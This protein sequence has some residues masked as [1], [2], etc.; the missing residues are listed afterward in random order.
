MTVGNVSDTERVHLLATASLKNRALIALVTIV[1]AVFGGLALTSL[2][3]ELIPSIE[4][5]QIVVVTQYQGASPEVVNETVSTPIEQAVRGVADVESTSSTSSTG[6]SVVNATFRYGVDL[7]ASENKIAAAVSRIR[8]ALPAD[9]DPQVLSGSISDLPIVQLAVSSSDQDAATLAARLDQVAVPALEDLDGVRGVSVA[10]APGSRV[11]ITPNTDEL[12]ARGISASAIRD[13]VSAS[14][15]LVPAGT[16]TEDGKT[17]SVQSGGRLTSVDELASL[18]IT[19]RTGI[20]KISDVATVALT[21]DPVTSLSRVNG[22]PALTLAITK[23]PAANTVEVSHAV[24]DAIPGIADQLDGATVTVVF[25][26]APYIEKSIEALTTEGLLGLIFA[27]LVILVFLLSV[28]ATLV[29][30]ISIPVSVLITFVGMQAADYTLNILTLGGL[31]IAIGRVVDDSIVV[32]E[33]IKRHLA[34]DQGPRVGI[35]G[36]AVREVAGAITASTITTVTV[37]LPIA[38]VGDT[39]GELFRPFALTVTI[40]LL[41]S[42]LVSL[43]IVPVLAY[44]L[45]RAPKPHRHAPSVDGGEVPSRLQKRYLP[46]LTG[47]LKH[48][49]LTLTA[50]FLVL[51]ISGA[52]VPFMKTNFLG[53]SGQNT[54]SV[55]QSFQPGTSLEVQ[56]TAAQQVESALEQVGGI[57]TV[58][59]SL[60]T[61]GSALRDAFLGG[62]GSA[63]A[64]YSITTDEGADQEKLQTDVRAKLDTITGEGTFQVAASG[65]FGGSSTIDVDISAPSAD[66]LNTATTSVLD[67]VTGL[68]AVAE[69]ASN[70]QA[71]QPYIQV[72]VNRDEAARAGYTEVALAG[73]VSNAMQASTIG[74]IT[75]DEQRLTIYIEPTSA[76]TTRDALA[77][78]EVPTATGQVRLDSLASVQDVEGPA[79]ITSANGVRTATVSIT[80]ASDDLTTA[81]AE[82]RKAVDGLSL[83]AGSTAELGGVTSQQSDAFGQLGLALL[84]AILIVYVVMVATF[85]SLLQPVLLLVSVPFAATGA[86]LLQVV[87]GI[88]LGVPSLIGVLMLIGIVVTNAIVLIDL[89]NQYRE[90]GLRVREALVEGASRRLRPILMTALATIFAL[91]PMASGLTGGG[92]FISQPLAL[93]VIGG[94]LSS[95]LLTLIVL[96]VLYLLVFGGLERRRERRTTETPTPAH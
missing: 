47:T 86:I 37:F 9:L 38:F 25:D 7:A 62:G 94:L 19:T 18:P 26:Q 56:D 63:S 90:K 30:A 15:V 24:A 95:T 14:G 1:A 89:V 22:E 87:T 71:A 39:T 75:I 59:V 17:L 34:T 96:P 12:T 67:A 93:V 21:T 2:K 74:N 73:Y 52:L 20:A 23:L 81:N 82:V 79:T 72:A 28:R 53:N 8:S 64:T 33:N 85:K 84:A 49:W 3:Q 80:P 69:V 45:I 46:I 27:V 60:G 43:T 16:I 83:P 92:G 54:L 31:T 32:I 78:L 6:Q 13:A 70:L 40:A 76:P 4:F 68:D 35:V 11:T 58:Q 48:P 91:L 66:E 55:T 88:P 44:W 36:G 41:A 65:G 42:L 10:G 57:E 77:A 50:A 61:S 51:L 5:P 29:T